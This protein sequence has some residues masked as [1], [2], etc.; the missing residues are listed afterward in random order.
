MRDRIQHHEDCT[1]TNKHHKQSGHCRKG[2][3][4]ARAL[5][6]AVRKERSHA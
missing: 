1:H 5:V 4:C 2:C 6:K 3:P